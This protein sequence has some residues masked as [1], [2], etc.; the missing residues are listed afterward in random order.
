MDYP[1]LGCH[2]AHTLSKMVAEY[3][4]AGWE[5]VGGVSIAANHAGNPSYYAQ[6]MIRRPNVIPEWARERV[7]EWYKSRF[8]EGWIP[9]VAGLEDHPII[10]LTR[11]G[12]RFTDFPIMEYFSGKDVVNLVHLLWK[13]RMIKASYASGPSATQGATKP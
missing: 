8:D 13:E 12:S 2:D 10:Y 3:L 7:T 4:L 5:L 6:A 11:E 1:I 9:G